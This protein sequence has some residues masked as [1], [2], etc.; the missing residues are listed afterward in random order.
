MIEIR[1][2]FQLI[3]INAATAAAAAAAAAAVAAV[4]WKSFWHDFQLRVADRSD[5]AVFR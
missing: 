3:I 2:A 5:K 1:N 4:K